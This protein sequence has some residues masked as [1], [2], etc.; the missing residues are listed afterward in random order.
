MDFDLEDIELNEEQKELDELWK[1]YMQRGFKEFDT[2]N[3]TIDEIKSELKICIN[4]NKSHEKLY[5]YGKI[6]K[7]IDY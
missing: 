2:W 1:K 4:E 5:K 7:Y 3:K 6:K